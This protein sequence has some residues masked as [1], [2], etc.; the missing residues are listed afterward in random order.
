MINGV[1]AVPV[2]VAIMLMAARPAVM[3]QFVL[4]NSLKTMGWLA[5]GVMAVATIG[6]FATWGD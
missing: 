3:G 1:V 4:S 6:M 2:M 5:T